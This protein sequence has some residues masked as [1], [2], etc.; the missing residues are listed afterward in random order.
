MW[1]QVIDILKANENIGP[2][3][4]LVCPRHPSTRIKVSTPEE[5]RMQ[6][7]E[8]GCSQRCAQ[9]LKC[10]HACVSSCHS[11]VLHSAVRCL[12]PCPRPKPG[13]EHLCD[14]HCGDPCETKCRNKVS[15]VILPCRHRPKT[16]LC[17]QAQNPS[18]EYCKETLDRTVPG[19][20]HVIKTRCVDNVAGTEFACT[21]ECGSL[22]LCGHPCKQKCKDCRTRSG[23]QVTQEN[24]APCTQVCGRDYST[25]S[26]RCDQ[27]CHGNEPCQLCS[28][29]C[30]V[31][32]AHSECAKP[33]HEPCSPCANPVCEVGC[34][35]SRCNAPCAVPCDWLP[36]SRRC[37]KPLMCGHR[38]KC[39]THRETPARQL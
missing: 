10:G 11:D 27:P 21:A 36:C 8:G 17:W 4:S 26:H 29:R 34:S 12:E 28:A 37:E 33:C 16:L 5:F 7:P 39:R 30:E 2:S 3:L 32:C 23:N 25:C 19:C 13:C 24:H 35:H 14:R 6:S 22:L 1:Q 38:C 20:N 31:R 18:L 9:R 15:G